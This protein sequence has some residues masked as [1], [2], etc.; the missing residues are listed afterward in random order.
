MEYESP[1]MKDMCGMC[2]KACDECASACRKCGDK[3]CSTACAAACDA[4]RD[5]CKTMATHE[6]ECTRHREHSPRGV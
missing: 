2:A 6:A 5:T 1:L 3:R 4:C